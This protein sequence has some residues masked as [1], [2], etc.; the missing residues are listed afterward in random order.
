MNVESFVMSKEEAKKLWKEYVEA[1]K[2]NPSDKF[3]QDM[4]NVYNQL[5]CGRKVVDI[6]T[7]FQRSGLTFNGEPRLAIAL[8]TEKKVRCTYSKDGTVKFLNLDAYNTRWSNNYVFAKDI[9]IKGIFPKI[10]EEKLDRF[11][12]DI[13]LET[14]V[15]KIPASIRPKG[16]LENYYVLW[17][18]EKWKL[19]PPVDP[20]LLRRINDNMFV[21]VAGWNLTEL[22]RAVMKGRV[23]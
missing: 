10:P 12:S 13:V 1:C 8:A 2:E 14:I 5:S 19:V 17:E 18:V 22:E 3:L 16:K 23:W 20:Y 9:V 21:V 4:K 11:N 6:N 7:I 15:P